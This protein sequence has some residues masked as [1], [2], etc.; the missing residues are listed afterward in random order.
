MYRFSDSL[1]YLLARLGDRIDDS[2]E[3]K[4]REDGLTLPE[5]RVLAL[6][7]ESGPPLCMS[8][9]ATLTS[10]DL[11]TLSRL[12]AN[13]HKNGLVF[14][15]RL[16][17]PRSG[18][19]HKGR[20]PGLYADHTRCGLLRRD[21]NTQTDRKRCYRPQG[22][23]PIAL[24]SSRSARGRRHRS[25]KEMRDTNMT[26][27]HRTMPARRPS[28]LAAVETVQSG[29]LFDRS[30]TQDRRSTLM[31]GLETRI[32]RGRLCCVTG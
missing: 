21:D 32:R 31:A 2:F 27:F 4:L 13:M 20:S 6:L 12:V 5:Y 7:T 16:S 23:P 9:L 14:R 18:R 3:Q 10:S 26:D 1:L 11:S 25:T 24:R 22:S 8:E 19:A 30:A 15:E 17:T 28:R 29:K